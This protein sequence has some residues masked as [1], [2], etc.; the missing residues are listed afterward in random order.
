MTGEVER[1]VLAF[2][3]D[4]RQYAVTLPRAWADGVGL[5]PGNRVAVVYS[6][7]LVVIPK[8][9]SQARRV[10]SALEG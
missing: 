5:R 6:D 10:R 3:A 1:S 9:S 2:G 7:V 8:D 4:K